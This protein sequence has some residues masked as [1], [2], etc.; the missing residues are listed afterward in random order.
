[1]FTDLVPEEGPYNA[2]LWVPVNPELCSNRHAEQRKR[3][4][5]FSPSRKMKQPGRP[6]A[7][8][9][10]S[11]LQSWAIPAPSGHLAKLPPASSDLGKA[12][13]P[14]PRSSRSCA[15]EIIRG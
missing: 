2:G 7:L 4:V 1:M 13:S 10:S 9:L 14:L 5:R 8:P 6:S 12:S 3:H 15:A 11:F